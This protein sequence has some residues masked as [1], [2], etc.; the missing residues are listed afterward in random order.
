MASAG[1][2]RHARPS[3]QGPS[4]ATADSLGGRN[5]KN[6]RGGVE[7]GDRPEGPGEDEDPPE[8]A[9]REEE[10]LLAGARGAEVG[11]RSATQGEEHPEHA[12]PQAHDQA[13]PRHLGEELEV[14]GPEG[15]ADTEVPDPL[16]GRRGD[17]VRE[18]EPADEE[19][20]PGDAAEEPPEEGGGGRELAG[21]LAGRR[22]VHAGDLAADPGGE[23]IR[24]DA[25]RPAQGGAGV[26]VLAGEGATGG[27]DRAQHRVEAEPEVATVL[28]G[29]EGEAIRRGEQ[30]LHHPNDLEVTVPDP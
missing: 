9:A 13:L 5:P 7:S 2:T 30:A 21:H 10:E 19:T 1:G 27:E 29:D 18:R 12:A 23:G 24:V 11:E 26:E 14:R 20:D 22:H 25:V 28:E 17:R 16:E 4:P 3:R 8:K 6:P 15:L